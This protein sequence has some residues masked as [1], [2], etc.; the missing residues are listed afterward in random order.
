MPSWQARA[1]SLAIRLIVRRARWGDAR[2]LVRR[3]RWLFGA[4]NPLQWWRTRGVHVRPVADGV[5]RGEWVRAERDD[6]GVILYLHGGGY[7]ACSAATHRPITAAL[8]QLARRRVFSLDYRLA[9]EHPFPA[10]LDDA[11]AAYRWLLG[12]GID[13]GA[14]AL[15]GDSAGGGLVLATLVRARDEALPLPAAAVCFSPWT[16]LAGTG[17]SLTTNNGRCAMFRPD[18]V[19]DFAR[20]YLGEASPRHPYASPLFAHLGG[21]PPLLLQVGSSEILLDDARRVHD[22]VR[23]A[24]G[25]STVQIFD[26]VFHVWQ[27]LDGLVPEARVALRQAAAFMNDPVLGMTRAPAEP[28]PEGRPGELVDP[29]GPPS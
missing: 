11:V 19:R 3:A 21:L 17:E 22:K 9:P 12:Q 26:G 13:A 25:A 6:Q 28:G 23:A 1:I 7:V 29:K 16:D 5:L 18:N 24:G 14:V 4:P 8:A 27:M 2:T 10:A 20:L 15:A